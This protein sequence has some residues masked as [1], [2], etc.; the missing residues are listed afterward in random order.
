MSA[1]PK[2]HT[3]LVLNALN[4][5]GLPF[6]LRHV[7]RVYADLANRKTGVGWSG[8]ERIANELGCSRRTLLRFLADLRQLPGDPWITFRRRAKKH[9]K[10]RDSDEYTVHIGARFKVPTASP[11]NE[12]PKRQECHV[13]EP[14]PTGSKVTAEDFRGDK[15]GSSK[16][17]P[18]SQ[19]PV[20][21]PVVD[22]GSKSAP[23]GDAGSRAKSSK[24]KRVIPEGFGELKAHYFAE[25]ERLRGEKPIF[26]AI[27]GKKVKDLLVKVTDVAK[28]KQIVTR[29]LTE[30]PACTI[31]E[32]AGNPS[33][34]VG[35]QGIRKGHGRVVQENYGMDFSAY[36][37]VAN[38]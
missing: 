17:P 32:I 28:G 6:E 18:V 11:E 13:E 27:E 10:G 25:F 7:I 34:W 22:P 36:E 29:A 5:S 37:E 1:K 20:S 38:G 4:S 3:R 15:P 21:D 9:G 2:P 30:W 19:D 24:G 14:E 8:H 26:G 23:G 12:D 35:P 33:K 16:V 31:R